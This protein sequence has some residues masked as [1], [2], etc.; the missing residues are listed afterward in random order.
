MP[1]RYA[2]EF[3]RSVCAR[4]VLQVSLPAAR[5]R[6]VSADRSSTFDRC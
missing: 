3:R 6:A 1:K 4:L 5:E 2:R